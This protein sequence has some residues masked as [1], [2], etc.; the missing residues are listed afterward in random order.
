M[1]ARAAKDTIPAFFIG[2]ISP[3]THVFSLAVFSKCKAPSNIY[4]SH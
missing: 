3:E 4:P 2:Q 1:S